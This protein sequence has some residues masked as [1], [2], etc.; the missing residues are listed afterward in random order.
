M[1]KDAA[2]TALYGAHA[3]NG[4]V[5]VTSKTGRVGKSSITLNVNVGKSFNRNPFEVLDAKDFLYW[6]RM[7][8]SRAGKDLKNPNSWATG[9]D[10]EVDGNVDAWTQGYNLSFTGGNDKGKYYSSV[11][12]YKETGFPQDSYYSRFSFNLN[13]EYKIKPGLTAS[14]FVNFSKADNHPN[15]LNNDGNCF[16]VVRSLAPTFK[17]YNLDGSPIYA[18]NNNQAANMSETMDKYYRRDDQYKTT[19][20]TSLKIDLM[21]GLFVKVNVMWYL[22]Q[23]ETE[24]FNKSFSTGPSKADNNRVAKAGYAR[25]LDQTYN[26]MLNYT[27][28]FNGVHNV[29]AVVGFKMIDKYS[30]GFNAAGK[31]AT[32]DDCIN[33]QYT[34]LIYAKGSSTRTMS[35]SHVNERIMS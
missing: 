3:N 10:V 24:S 8:A 1:L 6:T 11:G 4:V 22:W 31:G 16:S 28:S 2:A 21:K 19:L 23:K 12:Y 17:G 9:H 35:T 14:D 18:I 26:A 13:G 33:L 32:S 15:A 30:Y 27:A 29:S 5:L 20:G 7:A 34:E 25:K